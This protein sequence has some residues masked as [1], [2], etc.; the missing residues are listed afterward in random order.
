MLSYFIF[1]RT[2]CLVVS[3]LLKQY[4]MASLNDFQSWPMKA[5]LFKKFKTIFWSTKE[6]DLLRVMLGVGHSSWFTHS[7][8]NWG[9]TVDKAFNRGFIISLLSFWFQCL[10]S[11]TS[12]I[13]VRW[14]GTELVNLFGSCLLGLKIW[15]EFKLSVWTW[16][17][18][19]L[20]FFP[21]GNKL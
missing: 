10:T 14:H 16:S 1:Q 4:I 18:L 6:V 20:S 13:K 5:T 12:K 17:V 3:G 21:Q 2:C 9:R 15:V 19:V 7:L 8:F 11:E